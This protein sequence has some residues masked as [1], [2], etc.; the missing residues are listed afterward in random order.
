MLIL[1]HRYY[2]QSRPLPDLGVKNLAWLSSHQAL[3]DIA[4][5]I[6]AIN[7]VRESLFIMLLCSHS[8]Q[9]VVYSSCNPDLIMS[10]H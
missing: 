10:L 3:A 4:R 1:E 7:K 5:F 9:A 2:G 8:Y 6:I